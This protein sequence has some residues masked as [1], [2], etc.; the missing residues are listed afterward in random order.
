VPIA[1]APRP[2]EIT[3]DGLECL[4]LHHA[5]DLV[6]L[7]ISPAFPPILSEARL[8]ERY[9]ATYDRLLP[10][11]YN[12]KGVC[13]SCS[14]VIPCIVEP[15][16]TLNAPLESS[17]VSIS[18][19]LHKLKWPDSNSRQRPYD[20]HFED[21]LLAGLALDPA[22]VLPPCPE[23]SNARLLFCSSCLSQLKNSRTSIPKFALANNLYTV[24]F[25]R[26]QLPT[27]S[28]V[29]E[30]II[31]RL[32]LSSFVIKL[33][34]RSV[35]SQLGLRGHVI[36]VPINPDR[37]LC[38]PSLPMPANELPSVIHVLFVKQRTS[39]RESV[40]LEPFH[41]IFSVNRQKVTLWLHFLKRYV[42]F[43]RPV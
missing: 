17:D 27:L 19:H 14:I 23:S 6:K 2:P 13:C 1:R 18:R 4:N 32:R 39:G 34:M 15:S 33:T 43:I 28:F 7:T 26:L 40:S 16:L 25:M 22:G 8:R 30:T 11:S 29:E 3:N 5:A 42:L 21:P 20:D 41:K 31:A 36:G 38:Q 12:T 9:A 37:L 35:H 10:D 24:D